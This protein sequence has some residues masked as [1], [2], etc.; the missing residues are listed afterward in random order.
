MNVSGTLPRLWRLDSISHRSKGGHLDSDF[1]NL[2]Q[3]WRTS[4]PALYIPFCDQKEQI[5]GAPKVR[6]YG[7]QGFTLHWDFKP[8]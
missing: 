7:E 6:S 2:G 3:R 8:F 1:L 4:I 5:I